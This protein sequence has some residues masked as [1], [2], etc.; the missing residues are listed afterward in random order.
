MTW[1]GFLWSVSACRLDLVI[2]IPIMVDCVRAAFF[3]SF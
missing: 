3:S 2:K 1:V